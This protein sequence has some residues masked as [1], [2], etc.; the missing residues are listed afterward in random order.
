[1]RWWLGLA[2]SGLFVISAFTAALLVVR[3]LTASGG[4]SLFG[5][6]PLVPLLG[7]ALLLGLGALGAGVGLLSHSSAAG[8]SSRPLEP[9]PDATVGIGGGMPAD[10][11]AAR[12]RALKE[13]SSPDFTIPPAPPVS[14]AIAPNESWRA[15]LTPAAPDAGSNRVRPTMQRIRPRRTLPENPD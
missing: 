7:G 13:L 11:V 12:L 9:E 14:A 4:G 5:M 10:V 15:Q 6:P 3:E 8:L 2:G 1:M